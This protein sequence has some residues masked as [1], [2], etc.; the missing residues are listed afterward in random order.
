MHRL[1][2]LCRKIDDIS[3]RTAQN[4]TLAAS[5][6]AVLTELIT[7]YLN[8]HLPTASRELIAAT[9][10]TV[11]VRTRQSPGGLT[12]QRLTTYL[13]SVVVEHSRGLPSC[14]T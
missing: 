7:V 11:L 13:W 12:R 9:R 1:L 5:D 3:R 4:T 10:D 6:A 2:T 8:I 14:Q